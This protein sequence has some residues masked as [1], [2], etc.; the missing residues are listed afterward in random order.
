V[1][2]IKKILLIILIITMIIPSFSYAI[3]GGES[4]T[5]D[6]GSGK[7]GKRYHDFG[8]SGY[9]KMPK[10]DGC[11]DDFDKELYYAGI[12]AGIDPAFLKVIMKK[13]SGGVPP[14]KDNYNDNGTFDIGLMQINS[15]SL[16][17]LGLTNS[18]EDLNALR[19]NH[20]L[21]I[22]A[23]TETI[24]WKYATAKR[25]DKQYPKN[26]PKQK[27]TFDSFGIF[28]GYN[29][30]SEKGYEYAKEANAIYVKATSLEV[31]SRDVSYNIEDYDYIEYLA[32]RE[33]GL[34]YLIKD[35]YNE[36]KD[37]LEMVEYVYGETGMSVKGD[38]VV[39]NP[40][41][42]TF[43][44]FASIVEDLSNGLISPERYEVDGDMM[45]YYRKYVIDQSTGTGIYYEQTPE[46]IVVNFK[47][48]RIV[49]FVITIINKVIIYLAYISMALLALFWAIYALALSGFVLGAKWLYKITNGK[50]DTYAD[51]SLTQMVSMT[52]IIALIIALVL[53][54][55]VASVTER[56]ILYIVSKIFI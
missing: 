30:V 19:T 42:M 48:Y 37:K 11:T 40:N 4:Y 3:V 10:I 32:Y 45:E 13:E 2:Q 6:G 18:S 9:W 1:V 5:D 52:L 44:E 22:W 21:N 25:L 17:A 23:S 28:W 38:L 34:D 41:S 46:D 55:L 14:E 47:F 51:G 12:A 16:N 26:Y 39:T 31:T 8:I 56:A 36:V 43:N 29:G 35:I 50:I 7:V 27:M 33:K 53:S 20:M 49:K 54:G 15:G 24:K